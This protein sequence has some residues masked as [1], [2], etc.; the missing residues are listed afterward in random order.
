ML[1]VTLTPEPV[2]LAFV[3]FGPHG[4]FQPERSAVSRRNNKPERMAVAGA[5]VQDLPLFRTC[6]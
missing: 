6:C 3:S 5:P 1:T 4:P 2:A